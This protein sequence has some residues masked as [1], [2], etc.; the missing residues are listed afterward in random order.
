VRF[1]RTQTV[2]GKLVQLDELVEARADLIVSSIGSIPMATPGLPMKG[3]LIDFASWETGQVR[4][5]DNVFGLGNVL[6]GK[7]NIKESRKNAHE[8]AERVAANY[9]GVGEGDLDMAGAHASARA[10]A[11]RAVTESQKGA[12]LTPGQID[13]VYAEVR[14]HW[15]RTGYDGNYAGW[16]ETHTPKSEEV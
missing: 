9:L 2:D 7:G 5:F 12:K 11:E 4:G 3:E 10:Q 13:G 14:K 15:T 1:R 16:I 6:T 8:I